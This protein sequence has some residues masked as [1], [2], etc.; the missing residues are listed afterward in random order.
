MKHLI[1]RIELEEARRGG[2]WIDD[3]PDKALYALDDISEAVGQKAREMSQGIEEQI[4]DLT[5]L[6]SRIEDAWGAWDWGELEKLGIVS[7]KDKRFA[8]EVL[9]RYT[10]EPDAKVKR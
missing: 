5:V 2:R 6:E 3:N 1:E 8:L 7:A 9:G 4:R 10:W